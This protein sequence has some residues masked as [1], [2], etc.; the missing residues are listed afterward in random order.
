M[1]QNEIKR[2]YLKAITNKN[3]GKAAKLKAK[4]IA[5]ITGAV[6]IHDGEIFHKTEL[7]SKK[8]NLSLNHAK[9]I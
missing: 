7:R 5:P 2:E 6:F 1:K 9:S 4:I 3:H 8:P